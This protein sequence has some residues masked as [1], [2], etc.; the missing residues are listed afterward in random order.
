VPELAGLDDRSPGGGLDDERNVTYGNHGHGDASDLDGLDSPVYDTTVFRA[1]GFDGARAGEVSRRDDGLEDGGLHDG[2]LHDAGLDDGG[3]H[4]DGD[5][6]GGRDEPVAERSVLTPSRGTSIPQ[7]RDDEQVEVAAR[8]SP[9]ARSGHRA[10][11][12]R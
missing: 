12:R 4:D 9:V 11:S 7:Q 1:Q 2:G 6:D 5:V 10:G 3:L 8:P